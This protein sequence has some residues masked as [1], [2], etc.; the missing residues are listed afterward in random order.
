M[1]ADQVMVF[2]TCSDDRFHSLLI[3]CSFLLSIKLC[4]FSVQTTP[5]GCL[6]GCV[7]ELG[8]EELLGQV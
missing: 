5:I 6:M 8:L 2:S 4:R 7:P 3:T 1:W